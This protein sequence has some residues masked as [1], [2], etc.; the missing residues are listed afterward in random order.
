MAS[1]L[2]YLAALFL[3]KGEISNVSVQNVQLEQPSALHEKCSPAPRQELPRRPDARRDQAL[4]ALL[5]TP[6]RLYVARGI[7]ERETVSDAD[8]IEKN[9]PGQTCSSRLQ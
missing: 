2:K 8:E 9:L 3:L 6:E 5:P 1:L 7:E 4:G